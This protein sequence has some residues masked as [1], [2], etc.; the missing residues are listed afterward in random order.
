M[1]RKYGRLLKVDDW[2]RFFAG[3]K[4]MRAEHRRARNSGNAPN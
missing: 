2:L 1:N 3:I 4:A